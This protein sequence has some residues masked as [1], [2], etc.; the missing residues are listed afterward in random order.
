MSTHAVSQRLGISCS[1]EEER[2]W[3][4]R[5]Q[6]L[7]ATRRRRLGTLLNHLFLRHL[8]LSLSPLPL[9]M[10]PIMKRLVRQLFLHASSLHRHSLSLPI[11]LP[12][13]RAA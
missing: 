5:E 13:L 9:L 4:R 2:R 11:P 12:G 3:Q 7:L 1:A 8:A 6:A 10:T